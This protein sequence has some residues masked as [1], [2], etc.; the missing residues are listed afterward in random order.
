MIEDVSMEGEVTS[1]LVSA[2]IPTK[3]RK[4][5]LRAVVRSVMQQTVR[6]EIIC[7][8]DGSTDGTPEMLHSEFPSVRLLTNRISHGPAAARN[9]GARV[10]SGKYLLTLDDDCILAS[11]ASVELTLSQFDS[12]D[13]AGVTLPFVNV[14]IDNEIHTAAPHSTGTFV[15]TDYYA[16]MIL[17]RR[18]CFLSVNGYREEYFMHHEEPD[19]VIRLLQQGRYVKAGS[20]KLIDHHES[21][22]RDS[23]KLWRLGARNAVLFAVYNVPCM[24][25]PLH[26]VSTVLKTF[27]YALKRGG[28]IPVLLG[29]CESLPR[30]LQ[31][32]RV[33]DPV[34]L[35]TYHAFRFLKSKGPLQSA[36]VKEV[37]KHG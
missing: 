20:A 18:D 11:P 17:F 31:A 14:N 16:G 30:A 26:L 35:K 7:V 9:A 19:M 10:A 5:S 24:L 33:R 29:L 13:V 2:I 6:C 12:D 37:L 3:N 25:L 8:D 22:V 1:P 28:A 36:V 23:A 4:D 15:T 34:S 21:P 32:A 27:F